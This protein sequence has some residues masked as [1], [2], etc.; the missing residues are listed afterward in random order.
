MRGSKQRGALVKPAALVAIAFS[1]AAIT[2]VAAHA[3]RAGSDRAVR[4]DA[5]GVTRRAQC[6]EG[7]AFN[8][9]TGQCED[10]SGYASDGGSPVPYPDITPGRR[11][12]GGGRVGRTPMGAPQI[13]VE[14]GGVV[15]HTNVTS[16]N[17]E[18]ASDDEE[19]DEETTTDSDAETNVHD[20]EGCL[21]RRADC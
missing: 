15:R 5:R 17:T 1:A 19:S 4:D 16:H 13:F 6:A 7:F 11:G 12:G 8:P 2:A 14:G 10:L 20:G 21:D 18:P 3:Q 9:E